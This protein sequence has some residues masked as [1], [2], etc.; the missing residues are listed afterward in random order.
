L[1]WKEDF[2]DTVSGNPPSGNAP[3]Q[4][5]ELI[6]MTADK[7]QNGARAVKDSA[8]HVADRIANTAET[9]RKGWSSA[10]DQLQSAGSQARSALST[11]TESVRSSVSDVGSSVVSYTKD[12]PV[13][14]LLTAT[15]IGVV[16][17]SVGALLLKSRD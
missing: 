5:Q 15:A 14:A 16:I 1:I 3:K 6:G 13:K 9:A 7:V 12:N 2:M 4:G 11:A 8:N 10:V 17:G